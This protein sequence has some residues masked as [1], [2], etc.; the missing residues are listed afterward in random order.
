MGEKVRSK[1]EIKKEQNP[2]R[3]GEEHNLLGNKK[4]VVLLLKA[5]HFILLSLGSKVFSFR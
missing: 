4:E 1:K 5:I 2:A 3:Y